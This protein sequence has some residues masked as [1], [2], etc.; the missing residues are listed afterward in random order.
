[1]Y[2]SVERDTFLLGDETVL[3]ADAAYS[4]KE[5]CD[6]LNGFG[7]ADPVQPKG[8]RNKPVSAKIGDA[9]MRLS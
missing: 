9:M 5:T 1:V 4:W 6:K 2:D 3:Y 7:I 8:Y